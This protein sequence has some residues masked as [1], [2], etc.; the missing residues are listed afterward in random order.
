MPIVFAV[1]V[2]L[3]LGVGVT[4][5]YLVH[6]PRVEAQVTARVESKGG[7]VLLINHAPRRPREP[8]YAVVVFD[9][10][11]SR[12]ALDLLKQD[13]AVFQCDPAVIVK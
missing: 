9:G 13:P 1:I 3:A 6:R 5:N 4:H 12:C 7:K 8:G 11:K 2:L 10:R